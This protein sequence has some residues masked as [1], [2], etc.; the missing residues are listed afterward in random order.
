M[1][2]QEFFDKLLR[3]QSSSRQEFKVVELITNY[4]NELKIPYH[5]DEYG[6]IIA[7]KGRGSIGLAAHTDTIHDIFNDSPLYFYKDKK[8]NLYG[9]KVESRGIKNKKKCIK[10]GIGGDDKVGIHL[11]LKL[12]NKLENAKAFFFTGEEIGSTGALSMNVK[13]LESCSYL[14]Q[15]DRAGIEDV[16]TSYFG[17]SLISDDFLEAIAPVL[18]KHKRIEASGMTTDVIALAEDSKLDVSVINVS[19]GYYKSHTSEEF[20]NLIDV[21]RTYFLLL[22][23]VNVL[24][25]EPYPHEYSKAYTDFGASNSYKEYYGYKTKTLTY[26]KSKKSYLYQGE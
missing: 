3:T 17:S 6:N 4:L 7:K 21:K 15:I 9:Y 22:D 14:I 20:I 18:I 8:N 13:H 16:V 1:T 26:P 24:G 2:E 12:L 23:L 11:T 5:L 10:V 19:C 25:E